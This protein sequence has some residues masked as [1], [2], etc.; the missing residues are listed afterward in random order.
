MMPE[1]VEI[2]T[3]MLIVAAGVLLTLLIGG[4]LLYWID[5]EWRELDARQRR[6]SDPSDRGGTRDKPD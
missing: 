1:A 3:Q 6:P 5:R 2:L 4:G